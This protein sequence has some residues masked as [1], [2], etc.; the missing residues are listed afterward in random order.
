MQG[1]EERSKKCYRYG[2]HILDHPP[3]KYTKQ[4]VVKKRNCM[5]IAQ[6]NT[7]KTPENLGTRIYQDLRWQLIVGDLLPGDAVSIRK[8]AEQYNVSAMP[9]REALRQLATE[10]ALIGAAKKAYRVPGLGPS[11]AANLFFI[12]AVLEGASAEIVASGQ[13]SVNFSKLRVLAK[14]MDVAWQNSDS[15]GFLLNNF[16]FHSLIY[17]K[18][19]NADLGSLI[20]DLYVRT[21]PWLA[22]GII[23]LSVPE[24]WQSDHA[25]IVDAIEAFDPVRARKLMEEDARWGM[26]LYR[27]QG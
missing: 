27:Q 11:E 3:R 12:R 7:S 20:E 23:A 25:E 21:G 6:Q 14:K 10:G 26:R 24:D 4:E 5:N 19:G 22:R 16:H 17:K 1:F 13:R 18:T 8:L 2:G 9:V 15:K